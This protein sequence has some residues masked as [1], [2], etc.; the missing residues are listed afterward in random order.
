M[1]TQTPEKLKSVLGVEREF[2]PANGDSLVEVLDYTGDTKVIWN[3][4]NRDE[5]D[6]IRRQFEDLVGKKKYLVF[7][8]EGDDGH[9]GKQIREFDSDVERL[10]FV[11]PMDAEVAL[12]VLRRGIE[13]FHAAARAD[14][15]K[16]VVD[17]EFECAILLHPSDTHDLPGE[18]W[19]IGHKLMLEAN[20]AEFL[21]IANETKVVA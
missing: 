5:V 9:K 3:R 2:D 14:A 12:Y 4:R 1:E 13:P 18:D 17:H 7:V 19:A 11:P 20:E 21:R 15:V 8:A 16:T 6:A 10:I